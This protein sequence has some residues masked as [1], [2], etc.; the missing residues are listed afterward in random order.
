[1]ETKKPTEPT[2]FIV[3]RKD[4]APP[5]S[6]NGQ[7]RAAVVRADSPEQALSY[8]LELRGIDDD[9]NYQAKPLD[10]VA[11]HV[12]LT[13]NTFGDDADATPDPQ[14]QDRSKA[15]PEGLEV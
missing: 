6:G 4:T 10:N 14:L 3:T 11:G 5:Q 13:D 7:M 2:F 8:S 1:M 15:S 12:L 9:E